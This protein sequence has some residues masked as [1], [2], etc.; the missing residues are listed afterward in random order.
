MV[1]VQPPSQ[2]EGGNLSFSTGI[3]IPNIRK[4]FVVCFG[5]LMLL[6]KRW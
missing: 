5:N 2:N 6:I 3:D 4:Y 1:K